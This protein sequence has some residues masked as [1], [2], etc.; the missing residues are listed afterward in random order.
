MFTICAIYNVISPVKYVFVLLH[1]HYPQY[2][3]SAQ[4]GRFFLQI[5]N[6]VL[7]R[8]VAQYCLND[9]ENVPLAPIVNGINFASTCAEFLL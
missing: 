4:Y 7:S 5:L 9:F 8:Y 3:C 1:Q 2:V 6:F